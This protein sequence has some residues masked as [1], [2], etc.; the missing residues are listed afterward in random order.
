MAAGK[1]SFMVLKKVMMKVSRQKRKY[2]YEC[3][4]VSLN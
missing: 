3:E 1:L 2:R 4:R